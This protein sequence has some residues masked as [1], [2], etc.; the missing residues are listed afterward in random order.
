MY[1]DDVKLCLQ[2]KDSFCQSDLQSD[3]NNLQALWPD[4]L[5]DFNG[6]KFKVMTF[7]RVNPHSQSSIKFD[8]PC[9]AKTL[10][11]SLVSPILEYGSPVW[12]P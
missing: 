5:L 9:I 8:D 4:N 7:C 11:I 2:Y 6:Y 10:F 3:L 1:A 12:S